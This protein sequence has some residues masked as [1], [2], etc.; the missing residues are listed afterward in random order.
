MLSGMFVGVA[1][2][3]A[4]GAIYLIAASMGAP[5]VKDGLVLLGAWALFMV[6]LSLPG[7]ER[8]TEQVLESMLDTTAGALVIVAFAAFAG[9][10]VVAWRR[11]REQLKGL[12]ANLPEPPKTSFKRVV[13]RGP[14][15]TR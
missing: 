11:F 9:A 4:V 3:V 15:R 13:A 8:P 5:T 14:A 6:L 7:A 12:Q 1:I 10:V 2:V